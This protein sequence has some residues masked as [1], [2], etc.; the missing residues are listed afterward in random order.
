[1]SFCCTDYKFDGKRLL[2]VKIQT[3]TN[4]TPALSIY[5]KLNKGIT[6]YCLKLSL[7]SST[8]QFTTEN[9]FRS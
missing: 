5:K 4:S 9:Y 1:M 8:D 3:V 6:P 7:V 2:L